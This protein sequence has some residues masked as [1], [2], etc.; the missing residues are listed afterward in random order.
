MD[1]AQYRGYFPSGTTA[2]ICYWFVRFVISIPL[3]PLGLLISYRSSSET[4]FDLV[5]GPLKYWRIMR[6]QLLVQKVK[7][8]RADMMHIELLA[9]MSGKEIDGRGGLIHDEAIA[10]SFGKLESRIFDLALYMNKVDPHILSARWRGNP[11]DWT[12]T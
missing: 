12:I 8:A 10:R 2:A 5:I 11:E 3:A 1:I 7:E 9:L 4:V 6:M